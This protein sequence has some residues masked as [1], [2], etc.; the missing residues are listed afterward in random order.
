VAVKK[1]EMKQEDLTKGW[2]QKK[3]EKMMMIAM[4]T[5]MM[6]TI[7]STAI[8]ELDQD[9]IKGETAELLLKILPTQDEIEALNKQEKNL[10]KLSVCF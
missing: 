5:M 1:I 6:I 3:D 7:I 2:I 10:Q 8:A 9:K 4:F